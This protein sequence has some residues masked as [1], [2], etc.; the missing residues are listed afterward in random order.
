MLPILFA[1]GIGSGV[2]GQIAGDGGADSVPTC[3][4]RGSREWLSHRSSPLDSVI[5]V[6]GGRTAKVCYSRPS[7]RGRVVFGGMIE[8]GKLW[9]TGANEPTVLHLSF[10]AEV[11]GVPL[12][13][14]RYMLF[15]VPRPAQWQV[16]I[17]ASEAHDA[18]EM[19]RS[20]RAVGQGVAPTEALMD[21][22]ETFTIRG[23]DGVTEGELLLEWEQLA[24]GD[25]VDTT[26]GERLDGL[27]QRLR[28]RYPLPNR[29]HAPKHLDGIVRF[30]RVNRH[31]PL[32]RPGHRE[33]HVPPLR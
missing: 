29:T 10:A 32:R 18:V 5:L 28:R 9:R 11:A 20:M 21:P 25:T 24:F 16:A 12:P 22:V 7:A 26:N 15:T 31:L 27:H 33:E 1:I 4:V 13:K 14:G 30:G 6:I 19:F 8:Y 2:V 17:Y 23:V 3:E